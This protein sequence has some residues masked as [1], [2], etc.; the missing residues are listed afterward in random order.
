MNRRKFEQHL[1]AHGC[2]LHHHGAKHDVWINAN[3]LA[4]SP[5]PRHTRLKRGTCHGICRILSIPP[6]P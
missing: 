6:C 1:R 5:V 3:T 2:I 4:R